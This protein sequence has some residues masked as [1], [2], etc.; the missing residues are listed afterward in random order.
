MRTISAV[1]GMRM[2]IECHGMW[3]KCRGDHD[4]S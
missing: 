1:T 3:I 2:C 4:A